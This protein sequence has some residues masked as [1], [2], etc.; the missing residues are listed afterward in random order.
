MAAG[1]GGAWKVAYADFVTA[2]MAFFLV[3]WITAQNKAVKESVA[4]YFENPLGHTK[5]A[6]ASS[7]HGIEGA[8]AETP[9]DGEQ[10]GPHGT[11]KHA[12][13]EPVKAV[14]DEASVKRQPVLR[15]FERLDRTREAG[16]MILFAEASAELDERARSQIKGILPML[17][18]KPHKIELRGH[19]SRMPLPEGSPYRDAFEL[20]YARCLATRQFL[21]NAGI[22][23]SRIRLSQDG[24]H[25]PY[26]KVKDPVWRSMNSRVEIFAVSELSRDFKPSTEDRVGS[27]VDAPDQP[28][29]E[30]DA[31]SNDGHKK[32]AHGSHGESKGHGHGK[33]AAAAKKHGGHGQKPAK[34]G[35]H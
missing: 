8:S 6:R 21:L 33:P 35:G 26:S 13:A 15:I 18:G 20:C 32:S 24:D 25:E 1:G 23:E 2:M 16:T 29:P 12:A 22:D 30:D 3:M 17:H 31:E 28:L 14:P 27:F 19:A 5:E 4:Q 11:N 9:F 10:A 7:V 34:S